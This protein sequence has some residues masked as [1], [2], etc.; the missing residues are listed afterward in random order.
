MRHRGDV[1]DLGDDDA[2]IVDGSDGG[3]TTCTRTLYIA[4]NLAE[5]S[6]VRCLGSILGCHL[7]SV[8]SV[9]LGAS[10]SALS[11]RGPADDLTLVVGKSDNHVV[12]G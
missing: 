9:L 1:N 4:L 7:G 10:E 8:R 11:S 6:V 12:E 2:C 3:L 5:A